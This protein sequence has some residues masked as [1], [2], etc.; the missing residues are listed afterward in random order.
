MFSTIRRTTKPNDFKGFS[1]SSH[2]NFLLISCYYT[3]KNNMET[4]R[5]TMTES[6]INQSF[7]FL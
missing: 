6:L 1:G 2:H 7:H 4:R 3:Y 5:I